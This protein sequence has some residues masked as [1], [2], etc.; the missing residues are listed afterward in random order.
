MSDNLA[1]QK[2]QLQGQQVSLDK[3]EGK[4]VKLSKDFDKFKKQLNTNKRSVEAVITRELIPTQSISTEQL[5][6]S[7]ADMTK[8]NDKEIQSPVVNKNV[9]EL[10]AHSGAVNV[11]CDSNAFVSTAG[12]SISLNHQ[13]E[14]IAQHSCVVEPRESN[15]SGADSKENSESSEEMDF[16][17]VQKHKVRRLYLGGVRECV[18]GRSQP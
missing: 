4:F 11:A 17:G 10:N 5:P 16:V 9:E 6:N 8:Q 1:G 13:T 7:Y 15:L 12:A 3:L 18:L 2:A 14:Q